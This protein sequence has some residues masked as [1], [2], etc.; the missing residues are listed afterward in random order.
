MYDVRFKGFGYNKQLQILQ[1]VHQ[2][3]FRLIILADAWLVHLPHDFSTGAKAF[4][5]LKKEQQKKQPRDSRQQKGRERGSTLAKADRE[6]RSQ[7]GSQSG[8]GRQK[9]DLRDTI[10]GSGVTREGRAMEFKGFIEGLF[11]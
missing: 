3:R 6:S 4:H 7:S 11:K 8:S 5:Q 10:G 1:L 2:R 9:R